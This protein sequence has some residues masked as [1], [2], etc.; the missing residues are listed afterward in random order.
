MVF[1]DGGLR[2]NV[3]WLL[4]TESHSHYEHVAWHEMAFRLIEQSNE[5]P[6][7]DPARGQAS[8]CGTSQ[9]AARKMHS[10]ITSC[11]F[12]W[13]ASGDVSTFEYGLGMYWGGGA[14]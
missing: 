2:F 13:G 4:R 14:G 10:T 6:G 3:R 1:D 8:H 12:E 9:F 7:L 5:K 11:L